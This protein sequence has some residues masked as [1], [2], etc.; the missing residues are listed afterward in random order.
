MAAFR[1]NSTLFRSQKALSQKEGV[2]AL[3]FSP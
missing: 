2:E 1:E 3:A